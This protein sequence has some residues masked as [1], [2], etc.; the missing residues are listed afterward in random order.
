VIS[1][2]SEPPLRRLRISRRPF[3]PSKEVRGLIFRMVVENPTWGVPRIHG[4]LLLLGFDVSER[5]ISR[6]VLRPLLYEA[7]CSAPPQADTQERRNRRA[8][9]RGVTL[10]RRK[11]E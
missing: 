7:S 2:K 3:H 4:E 5:T 8:G 1:K 9:E 6:C 10:W 11:R